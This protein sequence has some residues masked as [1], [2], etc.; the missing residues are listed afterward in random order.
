LRFL[1]D[2]FPAVFLE[3]G[4]LGGGVFLAA[5]LEGGTFLVVFLEGGAFLVARL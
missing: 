4:I 3:G 1:E 5:F 2:A